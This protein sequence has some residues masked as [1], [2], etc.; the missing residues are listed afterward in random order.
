MKKSLFTLFALLAIATGAK[1]DVEINETNFPDQAFRNF[2]L[3]Q[4]YGND[5]KLTDAEIANITSLDL[6][7][8]GI[9][10]LRG[11]KYFTAVKELRISD[12]QIGEAEMEHVVR[13]LP[14][15]EKATAYVY[16]L[17]SG[18]EKNCM[19]IVQYLAATEKGW[20]AY[21]TY[22][23]G[24]YETPQP[25]LMFSPTIVAVEINEE[26]FP[27]ANFRKWITDTNHGYSYRGLR[28]LT[29]EDI[30]G[31]IS[32]YPKDMGI[33]SMK[34][35]EYFTALLSLS[36][37]GNNLTSLDLSKNTALTSLKCDNNQLTALDLLNN[38]ALTDLHCNF[39]EL[40]ALDLSKNTELKRFYCES[41]RLTALDLSKNTELTIMDCC[42][43]QIETLDLSKNTALTKLTCYENG[44][45]TLNL[46]KSTA[47]TSLECRS[48]P[49]TALDVS[50]NTAL[51]FLDCSSTYLS[52]LDLSKNTELTE[53]KCSRDDLTA[54][55]VSN[56]TKL[57]KLYCDNNRL[58]S[59]DVSNCPGLTILDC[60]CNN[61]NVDNMYT[62]IASLP[63]NTT[64]KE[65]KLRVMYNSRDEGNVCT[66]AQVAFAKALGWTPYWYYREWVPYE[67]GEPY[68]NGDV[69]HDGAVDV[70][71]ISRIITVMADSSAY[72]APADVNFDGAVD[73]ADISAVI[74]LMAGK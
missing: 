23:I 73:V 4:D 70:A 13:E 34:G 14:K 22:N 49:L 69:N 54:L 27:D 43:N 57:T 71:D 11:I 30:E 59:L 65:H 19:S 58:L 72:S 24:G 46:P 25:M 35:I 29:Y 67:G 7:N 51:T 50:Q 63:K 41:N 26:N 38:T 18:T 8:K 37:S 20:A 12:N 3:A 1:A 6:R 64:D 61:I 39:N 2:L 17:S 45:N 52:T 66:K 62:L 44:L 31:V 60:Y 21:Y 36:C 9:A 53:L 40:T 47:L 55:D 32:I 42:M 56:N 28:Y 10:S 48:N 68:M 74:T 16:N 33:E 5:G 15:Q